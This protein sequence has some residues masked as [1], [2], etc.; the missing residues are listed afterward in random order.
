MDN[1]TAWFPR[2]SVFAYT[3][4]GL[5]YVLNASRL[6][7][8]VGSSIISPGSDEIVEEFNISQE[9]AVLTVSL[10]VLGFALGKFSC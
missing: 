1:S 4:D 9:V 8:S 3:F 6:A 10:Y 5:L 7:G 2:V